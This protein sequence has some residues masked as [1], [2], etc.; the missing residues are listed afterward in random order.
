MKYRITRIK[1]KVKIKNT[2]L[3]HIST[4]EARI[5]AY[6]EGL[7]IYCRT[8]MYFIQTERHFRLNKS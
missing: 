2:R 6:F 8:S 5:C 3:C 4:T 7:M 1:L